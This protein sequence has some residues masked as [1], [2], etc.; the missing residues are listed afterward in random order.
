MLIVTVATPSLDDLI[1]SHLWVVKSVANTLKKSCLFSADWDELISAGNLALVK[2]AHRYEARN[3][4]QF[5]TY[6]FKCIRGEML[7][8]FTRIDGHH[9]SAQIEFVSLDDNY[10][11]PPTQEQQVYWRERE[12]I[13]QSL[14]VDLK[15]HHREVIDTY[16][17]GESLIQLAWDQGMKRDRIMKWQ[18]T[19]IKHLVASGTTYR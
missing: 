8:S 4:C 2:A 11:T 5:K 3:G 12:L 1:I 15:P 9:D 14:L 18:R 19:G 17:K 6:A 13:F 10:T 16:L 7:K